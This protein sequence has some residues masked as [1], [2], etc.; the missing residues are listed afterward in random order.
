[1]VNVELEQRKCTCKN[2]NLK[3]MHQQLTMGANI[4]K[5]SE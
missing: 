3:S 2:S 5:T 4:W 1:M